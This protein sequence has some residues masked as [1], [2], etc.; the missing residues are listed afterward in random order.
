MVVGGIFRGR[1]IYLS[2]NPWKDI[3]LVVRILTYFEDAEAEP[4]I[5]VYGT[6]TKWEMIKSD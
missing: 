2:P 3:G 4:D 5:V 6:Y 1:T